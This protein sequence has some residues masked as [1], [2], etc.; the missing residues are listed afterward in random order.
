MEYR[1]MGRTGLRV[2]TI[3]LGTMTFGFQTD[4]PTALRILDTAW[5]A[6]VNF[7]DTS[8]VYP[9]GSDDTGTTEEIIGSW[10]KRMPRDRVVVAT[11]ARGATGP[12]PNDVGLS[13]EHILSAVDASL[14]RLGTDYIDL[15][16]THF[17]DPDT[18]IEETMR[19]LE[20]LVRWGKVRY[21]GCSNYQAWELAQALAVSERLGIGRYDCDQP[22]YNILYRES[23]NE[24][25]PLCR[26]E[27]VGIIAYNPLAGGFLTGKYEGSEDLRE[28]TRF[29]LGSAGPRY[30]ARYWEEAQFREIE[31][32]R[33]YFGG[34]GISMTHAAVAWVIAQEGVTSAI[35]GASGPDQIADSVGGAELTLSEEDLAF[36]DESWFNLPRKRDPAIALR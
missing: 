18:P 22:R 19:A 2:S 16:Q 21:L 8:D 4:Q 9:L 7:L 35:V 11:K 33:T 24:L 17:P 25:L 14:A 26:A 1:R 32:L 28:N 34:R 27:G 6:G 10:L 20:D 31:R 13:R 30:R 3:C 15:Y 29:T 36:C 12:G 23:E 5:E